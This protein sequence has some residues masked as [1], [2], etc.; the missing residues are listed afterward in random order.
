MAS[1]R[2]GCEGCSDITCISTKEVLSQE[3]AKG[4]RTAYDRIQARGMAACLFGSGGTCCRNCNM[5]P[6]QIIDGVEEMIGVCGANAD[7]VASRNFARIVAAGTAA[8]TDHAREMVR[9]FIETAKGEGPHQIKDVDKLMRLARIFNIAT[10]DREVNDIALELGEKALAEFG[11]QDDT[12]LSMLK[13]A[14]AKR[15][16]IWKRLGGAPRRRS[17]GRGDDASDAYGGRSGIS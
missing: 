15:Q 12:P 3:V 7:T 14:P 2:K 6:C 4:V 5:G 16:E 11:N 17:R 10:E 8:H 13:R 1:K 9:G